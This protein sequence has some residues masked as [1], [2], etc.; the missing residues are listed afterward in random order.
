MIYFK[1]FFKLPVWGFFLA[2][3]LPFLLIDITPFGMLFP[4][5]AFA[6]FLFVTYKALKSAINIK[7]NNQT[8]FLFRLI[9]SLFYIGFTEFYLASHLPSLLKPVHIFAVY[10]IFSSI[11]TT[12]KLLV[13]FEEGCEKRFDRYLG[14]FLLFWFYPIGIWILVPRIKRVI[15]RNVILG[16]F[17]NSG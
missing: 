6:I 9:F 14:T 1:I 16:E 17:K 8:W 7:K 3:V 15:E 11:Y 2:T 12:A 10:C 4:F 13:I 5:M